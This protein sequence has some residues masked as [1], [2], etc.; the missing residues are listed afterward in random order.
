MVRRCWSTRVSDHIQS[1]VRVWDL[2][3]WSVGV[4]GVSIPDVGDDAPIDIT[5]LN[6]TE[7]LELLAQVHLGRIG[8]SIDALPVILPVHFTVDGE[9]VVFR[10]TAGTK[11]DA[12]TFGTVVAFQAD[13][14]ES[15][16]ASGWSVMLQGV[17]ATVAHAGPHLRAASALIRP[18]VQTD[19]GHRLVR[20]EATNLT[21]RRFELG[22]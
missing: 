15:Q 17:A 10:S 11:L 22:R 16:G 4:G 19:G 9:S 3:P 20:V 14:Y 2:R 6:R 21:G 8:A 13:W 18:W 5:V 7:C 12:A 1:D